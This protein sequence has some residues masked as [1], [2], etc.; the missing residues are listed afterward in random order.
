M[1]FDRFARNVRASTTRPRR[2][3]QHAV[4]S[5]CPRLPAAKALSTLRTMRLPSALSAGARVALIAPAGP[6]R[7]P[8]ELETSVAQARS[9]GWEPEPGPHVLRRDGYLAGSDAE[10]LL[11]LNAALQD[12]RVDGVWCVRGGYGAMR[13]LAGVD[14][15]AMRRRPK[16][17]IGYSDITALHAAFA[18]H[19]GVV[20]FH[21]PTARGALT[22]FSR[23]SLTRAVTAGVDSCGTAGGARTLRGGR[24]SG[25]LVGGNLALLAALA[26]TPYAPSYEGA[27]LVVE[28]VGEPTY[29]IDRM[30]RQLALSGALGR[31]AGIAF[32]HF[33]ECGADSDSDTTARGLNAVLREA[34][35]LAAVPTIAGIPL[36][37][38]ADQWTIPLGARAELDADRCELHVEIG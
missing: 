25:R 9:L 7:G 6:L 1:P 4:A 16:T 23:D 18:T 37:H 8:D 13:L 35:D 3:R 5:G 26:G 20:T 27:I 33:T 19:S 31:V 11:D 15:D 36:G 34:A 32:G 14:Y 17:L 22:D 24:A 12:D 29:R 10:R 38:V 30:L 21:G 28:D 2:R